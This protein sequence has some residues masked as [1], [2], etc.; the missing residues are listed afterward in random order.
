[1]LLYL[2]PGVEHISKL[3]TCEDDFY[4]TMILATGILLS[5]LNFC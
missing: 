1:M 5:K 2:I 3:E 4:L